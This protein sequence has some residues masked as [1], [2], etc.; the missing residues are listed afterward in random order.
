MTKTSF[1]YY[2]IINCLLMIYI[3]SCS[4]KGN[5]IIRGKQ[6]DFEGV[7]S[8]KTL[9][10]TLD[11]TSLQ[12]VIVAVTMVDNDVIGIKVTGL[13]ENPI[14]WYIDYTN[15]VQWS[16]IYTH[17]NDQKITYTISFLDLSTDTPKCKIVCKTS[18]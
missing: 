17:T 4:D 12:N 2:F 7:Y 11:E 3:T 18:D 14:L 5:T 16:G 9:D 8:G 6:Y 1:F 15:D 13:L 10:I